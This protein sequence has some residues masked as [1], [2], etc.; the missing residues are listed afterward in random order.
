MLSPCDWL[1]RRSIHRPMSWRV[2]KALRAQDCPENE[3]QD[4]SKSKRNCGLHV[5]CHEL[6]MRLPV[7][8]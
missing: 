6:N 2:L 4:V 1:H 8:P 7:E 5:V 3:N